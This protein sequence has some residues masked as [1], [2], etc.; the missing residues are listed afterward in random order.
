VLSLHSS[1]E[2]SELSQ[3]PGNDDSTVNIAA[4]FII[5]ST[6]CLVRLVSG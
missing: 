6:V 3:W 5:I 1:T 2:P 4:E